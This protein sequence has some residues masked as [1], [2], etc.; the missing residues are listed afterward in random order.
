MNI[1]EKS[2][3]TFCCYGVIK[4]FGFFELSV[5]EEN[6]FNPTIIS[7]WFL[8]IL[9]RRHKVTYSKACVCIEDLMK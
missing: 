2:C 4:R 1:M 6:K 5:I 9:L 7:V 3:K 8:M